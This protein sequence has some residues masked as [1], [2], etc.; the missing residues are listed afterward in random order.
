MKQY[1]SPKVKFEQLTFFEKIAAVC[2]G[3]NDQHYFDKD[4][5]GKFD[6]NELLNI[7][8]GCGNDKD[9]PVTNQIKSMLGD[10][11]YQDW[12]SRSDA[13]NSSNLAN[14]S[15]TEIYVKVS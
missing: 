1:E 8:K 9:D 11:A 3:G 5:D 7:P 15:A 12:L 10:S 13:N 2:W 14:T 6:T 4:S